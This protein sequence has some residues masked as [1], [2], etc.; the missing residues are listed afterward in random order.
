[1]I[2]SSSVSSSRVRSLVRFFPAILDLAAPA[3]RLASSTLVRNILGE[4][5]TEAELVFHHHF[6]TFISADCRR[7]DDMG[8]AALELVKEHVDIVNPNGINRGLAEVTLRRI[9]QPW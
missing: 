9:S 2:A 6:G 7:F 1:M 4:G 8:A 3:G 5:Q